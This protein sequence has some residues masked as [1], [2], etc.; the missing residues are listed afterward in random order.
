M[1]FNGQF[2]NNIEYLF[3][4]QYATEIN[5]IKSGSNFA[6]HMKW[7]KTLDGASVTAGI[8]CNPNVSRLI[9]GEQ[10]YKF[11][12]NIHGS[13]AYWQHELYELLAMLHVIGIPAWFMTL[14][15]ADLHWVQMI[16]PVSV[17]NQKPLPHKQIQKM[18]MK[19]HSEQLKANPVTSATMFQY[20]VESFFR[21]S[22]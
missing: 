13:P 19:E 7:G 15:A 2:A 10:A 17:H 4:T 21:H 14:S 22:I 16:E 6:L 20:Q 8:L 12:K 3:C 1:N 5:Q 18:S 11:Q 9:K